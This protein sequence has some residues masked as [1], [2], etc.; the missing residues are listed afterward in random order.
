[1]VCMKK[2]TIK[3]R[4]KAARLAVTMVRNEPE[5]H[6][7]ITTTPQDWT[8]GII[9]ILNFVETGNVDE[10][11]IS[12]VRVWVERILKEAKYARS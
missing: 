7:I 11:K 1:M 5:S 4:I 3:D 9:G 2:L 10:I 8:I 12:N 6:N